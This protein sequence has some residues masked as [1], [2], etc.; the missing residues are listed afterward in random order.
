[1][2]AIPVR[3]QR[4]APFHRGAAFEYGPVPFTIAANLPDPATWTDLKLVIHAASG[5]TDVESSWDDGTA[6]TITGTGPWTVSAY[7]PLDSD[8]T[9]SLTAGL[10]AFRVIFSTATQQ[11]CLVE[12][13]VEVLA[14]DLAEWPNAVEEP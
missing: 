4:L 5:G 3:N 14:M 8:Q 11:D 12:G 7:F 9:V 2:S 6:A 10:H 1:M 13:L